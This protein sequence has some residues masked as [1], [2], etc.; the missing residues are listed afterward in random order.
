MRRIVSD[1]Q[2]GHGPK[3][4][5][6]CGVASG[7]ALAT[8]RHLP[9]Q[10]SPGCAPLLSSALPDAIR[11]IQIGRKVLYVPG[12]LIQERSANNP[13]VVIRGITSDSGSARQ[14]P[15]VTLYYNGGTPF[16]SG[17]F[18]AFA[19]APG[20]AANAFQDANLSGY[21]AGAAAL[22]DDQL[23]LNREVYDVNLTIDHQ[24][25]DDWS[26]TTVN[27]YRKFDSA[28]VFDADGT[29]AP[30]LEFAELAKGWQASHEGRFTYSG[31]TLRASFGWN[32]FIEDGRQNVPFATEEG[33]FLQCLST[34]F[35][36]PVA[37]RP[38]GAAP[39]V[40]ALIPGQI[41]RRLR[42]RKRGPGL[43]PPGRSGTGGRRD[44]LAAAVRQFRLH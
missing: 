44:R 32:A 12:L 24:F 42:H 26:F 20:G 37:S 34:L 38:F 43:Q 28:E 22:G 16:V 31:K 8:S 5:R 18:P 2:R 13:G 29:A 30:F 40:A 14:G 10:P 25:E 6:P 33:T 35:G 17:R 3:S 15:R 19:G 9:G 11:A 1:E 23:G 4:A 7:S 27:G 39:C 41:D 21:P 36:A